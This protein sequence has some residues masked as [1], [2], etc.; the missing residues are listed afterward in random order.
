[1][2]SFGVN[3]GHTTVLQFN[4]LC[5]AAGHELSALFQSGSLESWANLLRFG[6]SVAGGVHGAQYFGFRSRYELPE[7]L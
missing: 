4:F 7:L 3:A 6:L 5:G 1:M 2:A